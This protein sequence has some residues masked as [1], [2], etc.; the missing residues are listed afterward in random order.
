MKYIPK[1]QVNMIGFCKKTEKMYR[2]KGDTYYHLR[3]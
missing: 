3:F 2:E 1:L